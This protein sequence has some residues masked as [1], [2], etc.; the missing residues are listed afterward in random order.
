MIKSALFD[1]D[2]VLSDTETIYTRIWSAIGN[3]YPTGYDDF[4]QRIK[5]TTLP[6]ILST[7]FPDA[8]IQ[9]SVK[10]MLD[11]AEDSMEY[12][13]YDGVVDFLKDLR[14]AGIRTAIVTSSSRQKMERFFAA[15]PGFD[16]YFDTILSD[17]DVE[18]SKPDP[19]GYLRAAARLESEP[20]ESIVFEDSYNGLRAGQAAGAYVVALATTNPADSLTGLSDT[21]IDSFEGLTFDKLKQLLH[22][23]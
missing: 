11:Q 19:D 6:Q 20:R 15:N 16:A 9:T 2:G 7:Y 10:Q 18:R 5:G 21:V 13:I 14:A 12:P 4:A 17:A 3:A 8:E 23:A 22:I 1:L